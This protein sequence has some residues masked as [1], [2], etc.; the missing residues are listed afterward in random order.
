M[1]GGDPESMHIPKVTIIALSVLLFGCQHQS[2][3]PRQG[4]DVASL[5]SKDLRFKA[6][7]RET[8]I[9][10]SIGVSQPYEL[11]LESLIPNQSSKKVMLVADKTEGLSINWLASGLLEVCYGYGTN[12]R[13][14]QNIFVVVTRDDLTISEVEILLLRRQ[15]LT[16]CTSKG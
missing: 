14:F 7:I 15:S 6:T 5:K 12:I 3:E 9:D 11:I 16:D 1:L 13:Q 4:K 8:N 2:D 10:G